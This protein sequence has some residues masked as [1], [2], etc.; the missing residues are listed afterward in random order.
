MDEA[1]E[2]VVR[3]KNGFSWGDKRDQIILKYF[4]FGR[5]K[6]AKREQAKGAI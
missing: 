4:G 3:D 6:K 1:G 2:K 5:K